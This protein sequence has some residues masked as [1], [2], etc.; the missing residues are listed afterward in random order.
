MDS[1]FI[2]NDFSSIKDG[3]DTNDILAVE[4]LTNN[5]KTKLYHYLESNNVLYA[6]GEIREEDIEK[7]RNVMIKLWLKAIEN[8]KKYGR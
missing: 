1:E 5:K 2:N 3:C 7:V 6:G 8:N 4:S